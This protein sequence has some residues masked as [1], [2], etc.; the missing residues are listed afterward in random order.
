M[1]PDFLRLVRTFSFFN[2]GKQ[3][4]IKLVLSQRLYQVSF[5]QLYLFKMQ[6]QRHLQRE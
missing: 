4:S 3:H 5:F 6:S 1:S 2:L